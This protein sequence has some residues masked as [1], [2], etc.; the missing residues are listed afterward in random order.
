MPAQKRLRPYHQAVAAV[1][2]EQTGQRCQQRTIGRPQHRTP[3]LPAKYGQ[4]VSQDEQL[5]VLGELAA[6]VSDQQPQHSREGEIG[7]RKQH[8]RM[9]SPSRRDQRQRDAAETKPV[10]RQPTIWYSRARV[11]LHNAALRY[12]NSAGPSHDRYSPNRILKPFTHRALGQRPPLN[13]SPADDDQAT[14]DVIDLGRVRRRDLLGGLI[15]EY[16]LAA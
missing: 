2:R 9:L 8:P 14:A 16:R 3:L 1:G 11:K 4:L 7:E 12:E 15:H 13:E 5:D 6:P 10:A